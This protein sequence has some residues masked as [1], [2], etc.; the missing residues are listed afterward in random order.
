M[1]IFFALTV[2][3]LYQQ[4][5]NIFFF[6]KPVSALKSALSH[7]SPH[8]YIFT[9]LK[10]Y[11]HNN[12]KISAADYKIHGSIICNGEYVSQE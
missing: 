3:H 5:T 2:Q 6:I 10:T 4:L 1:F 12:D 7:S 11:L 9:P 8:C